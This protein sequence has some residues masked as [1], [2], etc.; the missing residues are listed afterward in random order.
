MVCC[1]ETD[2]VIVQGGGGVNGQL[3]WLTEFK[4][5]TSLSFTTTWQFF[6]LLFVVSGV[7]ACM[8]VLAQKCVLL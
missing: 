5:Q 6:C 8:C 4:G 1:S 3:N 7:N 2:L